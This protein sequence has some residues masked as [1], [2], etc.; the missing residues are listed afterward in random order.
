VSLRLV[1]VDPRARA[2]PL[3]VVALLCPQTSA[4][5]CNAEGPFGEIAIA[6]GGEGHEP[7]R[8][9]HGRNDESVKVVEHR[10]RQQLSER[11]GVPPRR[12]FAAPVDTV[13]GRAGR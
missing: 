13:P 4:V 12:R 11:T 3:T 9:G 2:T 1:L 10:S 5:D 7:S 8:T 6:E